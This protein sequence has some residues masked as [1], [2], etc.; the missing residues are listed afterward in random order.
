MTSRNSENLAFRQYEARDRTPTPK[1][2]SGKERPTAPSTRQWAP[3][4]SEGN[5]TVAFW[6]TPTALSRRHTGK[7]AQRPL[8]GPCDRRL[9]HYAR[10]SL[11]PTS[12]FT[13]EGQ[14][15]PRRASPSARSQPPLFPL[16]IRWLG[17]NSLRLDLPKGNFF[18]IQISH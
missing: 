2:D 13:R 7:L 12:N 16:K 3:L 4:Q 11:R 14:Q 8:P 17:H 10:K 15:F 6:A 5:I 18:S 1:T 9:L